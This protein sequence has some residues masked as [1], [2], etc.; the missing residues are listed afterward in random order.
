LDAAGA[1]R[2]AAMDGRDPFHPSPLSRP[3]SFF[4]SQL[5]GM[6]DLSKSVNFVGNGEQRMAQQHPRAGESHDLFGLLSLRRLVA[7]H[8]AV[9]A[10]RFVV[11]VRTFVQPHISIV[12]KLLT[13]GAQDISGTVVVS[14]AI[15]ADHLCHGQPLA[16]NVFFLRVHVSGTSQVESRYL[17]AT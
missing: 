12:Q 13:R 5:N 3:L 15:D 10:G 9:G 6:P 17:H 14:G 1:R 4:P 8:G 11:A 16:G 7:V 2:V